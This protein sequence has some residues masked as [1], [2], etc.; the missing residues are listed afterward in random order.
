M[1]NVPM[2]AAFSTSSPTTL[3][4]SCINGHFGDDGVLRPISADLVAIP[5]ATLG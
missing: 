4:L 1:V 5:V 2:T 3:K